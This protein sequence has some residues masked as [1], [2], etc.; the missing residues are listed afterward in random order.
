MNPIQLLLHSSKYR[1]RRSMPRK[2]LTKF[3]EKPP[4][5][6]K[7]TRHPPNMPEPPE[8]GP[9]ILISNSR[10]TGGRGVSRNYSYFKISLHGICHER[11][12]YFKNITLHRNFLILKTWGGCERSSEIHRPRSPPGPLGGQL[13]YSYFKNRSK[14]SD[15]VIKMLVCASFYEAACTWARII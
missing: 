1:T 15:S 8:S 13:W 9:R 2:E 7:N 11:G 4:I 10:R 12:S 3:Y 6:I 5:L 14:R